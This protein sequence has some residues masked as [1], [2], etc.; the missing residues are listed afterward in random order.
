M[1]GKRTSDAT[2]EHPPGNSS[3]GGCLL[4]TKSDHTGV[5]A[6]GIPCKEHTGAP[7]PAPSQSRRSRLPAAGCTEL[8]EMPDAPRDCSAMCR[9]EVGGLR[10]TIFTMQRN[11]IELQGSE[12]AMLAQSRVAQP[13]VTQR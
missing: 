7:H 11:K 5:S 4:S 8:S 6:D 12:A 10:L 2:L 13:P 1:Q 3:A 9:A